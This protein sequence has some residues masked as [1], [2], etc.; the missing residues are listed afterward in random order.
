MVGS[1]AQARRVASLILLALMAGVV[2][3]ALVIPAKS[4]DAR[5]VHAILLAFGLAAVIGLGLMIGGPIAIFAERSRQR[6]RTR[7]RPS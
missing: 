1:R 6:R 5:F 2:V 7:E 3:G 4:T